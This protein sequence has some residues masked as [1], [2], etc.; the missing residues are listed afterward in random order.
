[1]ADANADALSVEFV[2]ERGQQVQLAMQPDVF[3]GHPGFDFVFR[4][5][6]SVTTDHVT[7]MEAEKIYELLGKALGK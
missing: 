6:T 5:A 7:R 2:N 1:M 4:Y 3:E